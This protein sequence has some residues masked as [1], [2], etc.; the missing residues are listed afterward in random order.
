MIITLRSR[1]IIKDFTSTLL[2]LLDKV[3]PPLQ[4]MLLLL[5]KYFVGVVY[6]AGKEMLATDIQTMNHMTYNTAHC[7]WSN[8]PMSAAKEHKF[9][10]AIAK[11]KMLSKVTKY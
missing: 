10:K 5:L 8:I 1:H 9:Q 11:D 6:F 2:K 7:A 4:R 3:T